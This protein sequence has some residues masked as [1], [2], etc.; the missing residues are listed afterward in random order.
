MYVYCVYVCVC[1][2]VCRGVVQSYGQ[3]EEGSPPHLRE[4][5]WSGAG[6]QVVCQLA[7][8]LH[9]SQV[10]QSQQSEGKQRQSR[11]V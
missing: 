8:F 9:V 3:Q 7:A 4:S 10:K 6:T 11:A 1:V 5:V 2:F